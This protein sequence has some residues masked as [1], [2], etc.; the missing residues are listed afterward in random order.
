MQQGKPR[1]R[2]DG[3][4]PPDHGPG[5]AQREFE[6]NRAHSTEMPVLPAFSYTLVEQRPTQ[7]GFRESGRD[8][9]LLLAFFACLKKHRESE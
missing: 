8:M 5:G 6:I 2:V 3:L 1:T 7:R 9:L 4:R